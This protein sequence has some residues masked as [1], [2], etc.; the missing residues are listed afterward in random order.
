MEYTLLLQHVL[1]H[2]GLRSEAE[3]RA[4]S[5]NVVAHLGA[6]LT[7]H[8]R[9]AVAG[10][11]PVALADALDL[12]EPEQV[13]SMDDL[14]LRVAIR[15]DVALGTALEH[16][17]VVCEALARS[18]GEDLTDFLRA[19]LPDDVAALLR[20][21]RPTM[22]GPTHFV[23]AREAP[24][25]ITGSTLA[26]GRPGSNHPLYEGIFG[27][28]HSGSVARSANP[29]GDRKI[30]SGGAP[31]RKGRSTTLSGGRPGPSRPVSEY[32]EP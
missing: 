28:G 6:L 26:T 17:H 21:E 27:E 4:V 30:S 18:L 32:D 23:H 13:I 10:R 24:V 1:D 8:D 31:M 11:L 25:A 3:A 5:E 2:A 15:G 7:S 22:Q 12:E 20:A 9:V 29:H 19:R 14:V 16:T